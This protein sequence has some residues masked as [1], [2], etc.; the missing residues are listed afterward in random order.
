MT[1]I[2]G[3]TP[4]SHALTLTNPNPNKDRSTGTCKLP[5]TKTLRHRKI[6]FLLL[7]KRHSK[8]RHSGTFSRQALEIGYDLFY[9]ILNVSIHS[10][11]NVKL[12]TA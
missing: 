10:Y 2:I 1:C 5:H 8:Q 12:D 6:P 3:Y 4:M 7:W 11:L 9:S